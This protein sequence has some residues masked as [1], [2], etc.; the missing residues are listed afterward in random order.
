MP[1]F[2]VQ[3]LD[4]ERIEIY[5]N[6]RSTNRTRDLGMMVA[7]SDR[8]I[9]RM[10]D[11]DCE[12]VSLLAS[13][14]KLS[15]CRDWIPSDLPVYVLDE[16]MASEL[17][18]FDFHAGLL[19]CALRPPSLLL[20][21][22]VDVEQTCCSLL[23]CPGVSDAQNLGVII[24]LAAAFGIDAILADPGTADPFSRRTLRVSTGAAFRLP[25]RQCDDLAGDILTLKSRFGF[26]VAGTVLDKTATPLQDVL[27][28]NRVVL[29]LGNETSGLDPRLIDLCDQL[30]TIPVSSLVDS[31]NVSAAAA[32]FLQHLS[33]HRVR[34]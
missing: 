10:I 5:R 30:W 29:M 26:T 24:R 11:S 12:M 16:S 19:G 23:A 13:D 1:E 15:R 20:N 33:Q 8:V 28:P 32:I 17:V 34:V 18:G 25:I 6:L 21:E 2:A 14:R 22:L 4:D 27:P 3:S 31:I 7:E 9:R